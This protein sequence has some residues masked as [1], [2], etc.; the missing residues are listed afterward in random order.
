MIGVWSWKTNL[1]SSHILNY[2]TTWDSGLVH[3][4]PCAVFKRE[5]LFSCFYI[6]LCNCCTM[7]CFKIIFKRWI[8]LLSWSKIGSLWGGI[9]FSKSTVKPS[10]CKIDCQLK[11]CCQIRVFCY[12]DCFLLLKVW[13]VIQYCLVKVKF[14]V[15]WELL[16]RDLTALYLIWK[17]YSP[18]KTCLTTFRVLNTT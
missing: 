17:T 4:G 7:R 13:L 2:V 10:F 3:H 5:N 11:I 8:N 1:V 18:S 15:C 6:L 12:F 9:K 14:N 16:D